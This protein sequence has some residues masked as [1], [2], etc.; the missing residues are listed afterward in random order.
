MNAVNE[1]LCREPKVPAQLICSSNVQENISMFITRKGK[2]F[3]DSVPLF[4]LTLI[5]VVRLPV[6]VV[7][8]WLSIQKVVPE[9]MTFEGR[10]YDIFAG[11]SAIA[12]VY[13]IHKNRTQYKNTI[14]VWNIISL[15]LLLNIVV[16][17]FLSSPS[18]LQ[19]FA[20]EQPNIAILYF[21]F[22]WLPTFIVP[23]VLFGHLASIRKITA[24]NLL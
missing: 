12:I 5:N 17:A 22:S 19:K 8:Y 3:I 23:I 1:G 13:L 18:P 15:G 7:L 20:F 10:N 4:Y 9:L 11:I 2:E 21:P 6:E 14:L 16:N 24:N